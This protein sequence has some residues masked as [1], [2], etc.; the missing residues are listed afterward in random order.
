M[1]HGSPLRN[2]EEVVMRINFCRELRSSID[3][4]HLANRKWCAMAVKINKSPATDVYSDFA[5]KQTLNFMG[6]NDCE[7]L[8]PLTQC[9][10]PGALI[11]LGAPQNHGYGS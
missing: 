2:T 6:C 5:G 7:P 8:R 11:F 10:N 4:P 9:F 3:A 1:A